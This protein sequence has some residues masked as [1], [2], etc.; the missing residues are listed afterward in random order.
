MISH[1]SPKHAEVQKVA[2][3]WVRIMLC[4]LEACC[5]PQILSLYVYKCFSI[6]RLIYTKFWF[7]ITLFSSLAFYLHKRKHWSEMDVLCS[8]LIPLLKG[9]FFQLPGVW[10]LWAD[11]QISLQWFPSGPSWLILSSLVGW[12]LCSLITINPLFSSAFHTPLGFCSQ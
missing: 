9:G 7:C 3:D 8:V 11:D 4:L 6:L 10:V 12:G 5:H 1:S 2:F